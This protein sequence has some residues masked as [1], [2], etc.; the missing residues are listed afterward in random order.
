MFKGISQ[1]YFKKIAI[2]KFVPAKL[3]SI[4]WDGGTAG[5]LFT[6]TVKKIKF[7]LKPTWASEWKKDKYSAYD[8]HFKKGEKMLVATTCPI[9]I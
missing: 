2:G 1:D 9:L 5:L 3:L 8:T 4:S 6:H 7:H